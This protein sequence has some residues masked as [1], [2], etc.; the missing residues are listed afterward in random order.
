VID[1]YNQTGAVLLAARDGR[2]RWWLG[3]S[4]TAFLCVWSWK[5]AAL[6]VVAANAIVLLYLLLAK[7]SGT[8]PNPS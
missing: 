1:R 6:S 3:V 2:W 8:S 4:I 7:R 5:L